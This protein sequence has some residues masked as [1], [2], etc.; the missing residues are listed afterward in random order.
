MGY[1]ILIVDDEKMIRMGIRNAMPWEQMQIAEVYTASS[2]GEAEELIRE[3]QPEIMITDI[4][5]TEMSG[6]ELVEQIRGEKNDMRVIVLTGYDRFDYA[7]Q[8]LQLQVHDFLLKPIDE[9]ELKKSILAQVEWLEIRRIRQADSI[10]VS[11]AQGVRQQMELEEFMRSLVMGK[12]DSK[13]RAEV[14]WKE[15]QFE[16]SQAMRIGILLPRM[17]GDDDLDSDGFRIQTMKRICIGMI[18]EQKRG[19]TFADEKRRVTIAFFCDEGRKEEELAEQLME[20]LNDELETRPRIIWGSVKKGLG[21][22][23]ISYNDA[24]FALEHEREEFEKLC[25]VNWNRRGED[26]FQDVFR[27]FRNTLVCNVGEKEKISHIFERFSTAVESYNLS[28]KYARSCCFELASSVYFARFSDT[29]N[30]ADEK[31]SVLMQALSGADRDRACQVTAMFFENLFEGEE[32][33]VHELVGKVKRRIHENLADDLTVASLAEQ[34]Y[35]T[36]N[37]L[38]RLFKRVTGEGCNEYIVRKRIEQAKSLL[39]TTT[40][41]VGEISIMVGYHDMNYFSLAFKK[42]IGVSPVKY[43]EQIQSGK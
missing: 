19:I 27:E 10:T 7:R 41:K 4:S 29:G 43:R 20:I 33:E 14:F 2:A 25:A 11:R 16:E 1:K 15:F 34:Y 31:L 36:P 32:G 26:I 12:E 5:M 6:L 21:N 42:H 22:L 39:A 30:S 24:V 17:T 3:H 40:L 38:S 35:V 28:A 13:K 9:M 18:D 37:Y 8:A 23:Y